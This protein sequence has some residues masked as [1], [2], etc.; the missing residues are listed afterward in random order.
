MNLIIKN[1]LQMPVH[2]NIKLIFDALE[3]RQ[4]E[5]NWLITAHECFCWPSGEEIFDKEIVFLLEMN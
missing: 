1:S 5:F 2:T 3:E 4:K